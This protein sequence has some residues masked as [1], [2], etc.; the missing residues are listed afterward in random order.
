MRQLKLSEATTCTHIHTHRSCG[1]CCTITGNPCYLAVLQICSVTPSVYWLLFVWCCLTSAWE[2]PTL[3]LLRWHTLCFKGAVVKHAKGC[4]KPRLF[5]SQDFAFEKGKR[6]GPKCCIDVFPQSWSLFLLQVWQM[7]QLRRNSIVPGGQ[8]ESDSAEPP[9]RIRCCPWGW[10]LWK[11][12]HQP[13]PF[14]KWCLC[15]CVWAP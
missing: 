2:E 6:G 8:V 14:I 1:R 15:V 9:V 12:L 5:L 7:W 13:W 4:N 3:P 11:H 10:E